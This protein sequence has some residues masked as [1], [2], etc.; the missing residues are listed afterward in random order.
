MALGKGG[1]QSSGKSLQPNRSKSDLS[2]AGLERKRI[3]STATN[4][5][6]ILASA[7]PPPPKKTVIVVCRSAA[8]FVPESLSIWMFSKPLP[9]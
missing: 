5:R 8:C 1:F 7:A 9:S 3:M 2:A 4:H 6:L